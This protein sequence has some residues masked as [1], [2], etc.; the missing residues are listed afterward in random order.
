[1]GG[2]KAKKFFESL[3]QQHPDEESGTGNVSEN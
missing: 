1:M 2:E 3:K